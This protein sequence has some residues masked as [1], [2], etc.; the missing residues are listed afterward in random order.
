MDDQSF[1]D[2][3]DK[4]IDK[5]TNKYKD[6]EYLRKVKGN[7]NATKSFSFLYWFLQQYLPNKDLNEFEE[8]ITEGDEDSSCD[9]IFSNNNQNNEEVFYVVQ[10]K[11]FVKKN[12]TKRKGLTKEIKAC[13]ADF[14]LIRSGKKSSTSNSNFNIQYEKLI[15]HKKKNGK[16]KF[17]FLALCNGDIDIKEYLDD[18]VDELVSF[19]LMDFQKIK[20]QYIE[21]EYKGIKTNNPLETSYLPS[22]DF[23]LEFESES[24]IKITDPYQSYIFI[25][26]PKM[27]YQFFSNYGHSLFYKN[28]RNPLTKS[29][30]NEE[31]KNT[32]I[33]NPKSFWYF[34]NG[35]TAITDKINSFYTDSGMVRI[36]G[37][38]IINGAQ[39]VYS[40]YQAY[41][42]AS[43]DVR[44]K[45]DND[46]RITMRVVTTG[47]KDF[48]LQVTRFTNSQNPV[49]NRDF[50]SNDEVQ[51]RLQKDFLKNTNIWY[52]K[53]RGEFRKSPKEVVK[54]KNENL[55]QSYLAYYLNDPFNAKQNRKL[56][57][58]EESVN[59]KGLYEKIFNDSTKYDDMLVSYYLL[60]YINK[61]RIDL[62]KKINNIDPDD[63]S[64]ND[65]L[66]LSFSFI[67]YANFDILSLF[68][69]LIYTINKESK[70][71]INGKLISRFNRDDTDKIQEYYEIIKSFIKEDIKNYN[72][73]DVHSVLFKK[74]GYYSNLE[75]RFRIFIRDNPCDYEFSEI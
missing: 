7:S 41:K 71:S 26:K 10:A 5:A 55:A 74:K 1:Y 75:N 4:E 20:E 18:F 32:I 72:P 50:H 22:S 49:D 42:D 11:W 13:L 47:G 36:K 6:N 57:F 67:Q 70:S 17:I 2:V 69:V 37:V 25:V 66:L 27:I 52:E 48:D 61:K 56:I 3:I 44:E 65:D 29:Y 16:I 19:E 59:S 15:N 40:I 12:I 30:F 62:N 51:V 60:N 43:E 23:E 38:Q 21:I 31:I 34:N 9:L 14:R 35:I 33:N 39:T 45:M 73:N 53:R 46:A 8:Y 24:F 54:L 28:I 68:K 63:V 64:N 58:V